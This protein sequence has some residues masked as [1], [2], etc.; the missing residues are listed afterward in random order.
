ML[1]PEKISTAGGRIVIIK[2]KKRLQGRMVLKLW[3]LTI[4]C[5]QK[6]MEVNMANLAKSNRA[7]SPWRDFFNI[8]NFFDG[9]LSGRWENN[10]PSVNISED[11]KNYRVEV[12]APGFKKEDFKVKVDEDILTI[13]AET[14]SENTEDNNG[15]EYTRREYNYSSFSRS[16]QLPENVKDDSI[17]ASYKDGILQLD[18]PKS[19][20]QMK[21]TKE[22]AIS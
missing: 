8:D 6:N 2:T 17:S 20:T 19:K 11:Q 14:K 3:R 1:I 4:F 5:Q 13:S 10:F 15:R 7:M 22:I 16:F 12:V 18:L 21:A 9:G